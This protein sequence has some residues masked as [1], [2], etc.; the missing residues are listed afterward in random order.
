MI[1]DRKVRICLIG[2]GNMANNVH[3]PSLASFDDV[4]IVGV[5]ETRR[6]RLEATCDKY[7]IAPEARFLA[8]LDT[9]YQDI[10][11]RL[12]PDGV[13]VVGQPEIMYPIWQW[14][15]TNGF[16]L[17]IEKPMGLTMHHA[18]V[19]AHLAEKNGL[20]TQV[21]HQRRVA[22]VM[23]E[24]RKR[25]L[26][27]GPITH[28]VVE[29][30]KY[31]MTPMLIARDR[32]LD[33]GTHAIDTARWICGGE[34]VKVESQCKRIGVPDI[35]WIGA[36]LHFDNGSTC[37]VVCSWSSGRRVFRAQMH[38]PGGYADV[39]LEGE[40]H[41]YLEGNYAGEVF[42]TQDVA[43]S[44]KNFVYGGFRNKNRE[45]IDSLKSGIDVCS[46]PFRDTIKTMRVC[47][48]MLAQALEEDTARLQGAPSHS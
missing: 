13:Y 18:E 32:M 40:A 36:T 35:N 34:V 12:K 45:F 7:G 10:L 25:L 17:Y 47:H 33:D 24:M 6:D 8:A 22:P 41:L 5:V 28:G 38:A 46:S 30:F 21:S 16:N 23:V 4:E 3:Y 14:C 48:T 19:L 9:D 37:F 20:I 15:L 27:K 1:K 11:K 26:E 42:R 44:D 29:F 2:A 31:D 39:E 43:Q